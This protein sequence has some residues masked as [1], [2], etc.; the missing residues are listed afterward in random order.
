[1][2]LIF[3]GTLTGHIT[4]RL[5]AKYES[6]HSRHSESTGL[7]QCNHTLHS[8]GICVYSPRKRLSWYVQYVTTAHT[9]TTTDA[10]ANTI[11]DTSVV[12]W[13]LQR[14]PWRITESTCS[15]RS[16]SPCLAASLTVVS[17]SVVARS[18]SAVV[19]GSL[20]SSV[21]NSM[22]SQSDELSRDS[23]GKGEGFEAGGDEGG[24]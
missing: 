11:E 19:A 5:A 10:K 20:L 6:S 1:L 9:S 17:I 8:S 7:L 2:E 4:L 21:S 12:G 18:E 15:L 23:E 24:G 3:N 16:S 14:R 22:E 13:R